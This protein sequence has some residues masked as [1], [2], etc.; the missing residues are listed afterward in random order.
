MIPI[1]SAHAIAAYST[2]HGR[3]MINGPLLL[4]ATALRWTYK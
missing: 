2:R 1:E 4:T 3:R